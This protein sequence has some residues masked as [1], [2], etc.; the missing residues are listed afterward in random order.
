MQY[1]I[2]CWDMHQV[3][4]LLW[5]TV[6]KFWVLPRTSCHANVIWHCSLFPCKFLCSLFL[7]DFEMSQ[8]KRGCTICTSGHK[9]CTI[10]TAVFLNYQIYFRKKDLRKIDICPSFCTALMKYP[11]WNTLIYMECLTNCWTIL[12]LFPFSTQWLTV[13]K[14][15]GKKDRSY[16][17]L[18]HNYI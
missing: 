18:L 4:L 15:F 17:L 3:I 16:T 10:H 13:L 14:S 11:Q 2:D 9:C 1:T 5:H 12:K 6:W 7:L 8:D